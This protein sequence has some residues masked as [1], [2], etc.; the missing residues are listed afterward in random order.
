MNLKTSLLA[1]TC[2]FLPLLCGAQ[3]TAVNQEPPAESKTSNPRFK[4]ET[5]SVEEVVAT[6]DDGYHASN[7]VVRWHGNRVLLVDP[8][9]STRLAVGDNASFVVSHH[10]IGGKRL[11]SFVFTRDQDSRCEDKQQPTAPPKN[12]DPGPVSSGADFKT[13][14]VEEVLS[15]E[16]DGYRSVGYIVQAQ[17]KRIAIADPIAQSHYGIG[18]SISFLAMRSKLK[19]LS[20]LAFTAMPAD[21]GGAKPAPAGTPDS[22]PAAKLLT[23]PQSGVITE[24]LT[25][26]D[27]NYSYRAYIVEA[28]GARVVVEDSPGASP[29]QVGEQLTFVSRRIA[30][31]LTPGHGLL[32]FALTAQPDTAGADLEGAH[33]SVHTDTATV[34]EVLTAEVNGDRYLAYIVKWNGARVAVSDVFASTHYAEGDHITFPV[35]REGA[36]GKG[37]LDFMMFNFVHPSPPQKGTASNSSEKPI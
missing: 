30:N 5:A 10:D 27:A 8:L 31:P 13:G 23:A 7:Y 21:A 19:G 32:S 17:G 33:V 25:T 36:T 34:D 12:R 2:A 14:I 26:S 22:T 9:A 11:L 20:L 18:D 28:L 24:V 16:D 6:E 37:R 1:T 35:A 15:A 4:T 29:H 3:Q